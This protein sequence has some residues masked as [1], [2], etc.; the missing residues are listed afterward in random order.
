M[1]GTSDLIHL[2]RVRAVQ[3]L[4]T[5]LRARRFVTP[6]TLLGWHQRF[7]GRR[8]DPPRRGRPPIGARLAALIGRMAGE[9]PG[10]GYQRIQGELPVLATGSAPRRSGR[11]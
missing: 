7:C 3:G 9:N 6:A 10:R 8:A 1:T 5:S 2:H 4:P 11:C